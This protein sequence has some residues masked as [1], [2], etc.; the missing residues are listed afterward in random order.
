[1]IGA[2]LLSVAIPAQ[3]GFSAFALDSALT[4]SVRFSA[5]VQRAGDFLLGEQGKVTHS[6]A[7]RVEALAL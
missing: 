3:A 7:E 2:S 4:A 5:R 6:S 1:L